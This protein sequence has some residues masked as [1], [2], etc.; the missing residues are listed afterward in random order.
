V[1][2][3]CFAIYVFVFVVPLASRCYACALS[4]RTEL[5]SYM[6]SKSTTGGQQYI[7]ISNTSA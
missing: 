3:L 5:N 2:C 1:S 4:N 7:K 6:I